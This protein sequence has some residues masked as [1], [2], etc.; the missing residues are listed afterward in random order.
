[1][2][3]CKTCKYWYKHCCANGASNWCTEMRAEE[4]GCEK[5]EEKEEQP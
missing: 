2:T 3:T 1:M 5:H 4:D